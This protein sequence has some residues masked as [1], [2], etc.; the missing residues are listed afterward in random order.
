MYRISSE[1]LSFLVISII[2]LILIAIIAIW[3]KVKTRQELD[4]KDRDFRDLY[5]STNDEISK[6]NSLN[7]SLQTDF[8]NLQTEYQNKIEEITVKK[9]AEIKALNNKFRV[10]LEDLRTIDNYKNNIEA[11]TKELNLY[12]K[13]SMLNIMKCMFANT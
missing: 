6:L 12:K 1:L 2:L 9:E 11:L 3:S 5:K 8:K 13:K 7:K 4:K 10:L